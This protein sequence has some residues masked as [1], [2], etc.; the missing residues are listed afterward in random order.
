M[1]RVSVIVPNYN[2]SDTVEQMLLALAEQTEPPETFEVILVDDGST[3]GSASIIKNVSVPYTLRLSRQQNRGAAAAR[4]HGAKLARADLLVFLDS[5]M[6]ATPGLLAQYLAASA[7]HRQA[8]I[9]GRQHPW[10]EAFRSP[11]DRIT[12]LEKF[13]DLGTKRIDVVFYHVVS[14]NMAIRRQ[15]FESLGGFDKSLGIGV[16][17]AC[18][19]TD[20]GYRATK[21]GLDLVYWPE[22]LAYH[23]HPRTFEQRCTQIRLR[24]MWTARL[25]EKHPEM[26]SM[27][28]VYQNVQPISW[29]QDSLGLI[30]R[31]VTAQFVA[32]GP[33]TRT[34]E[35]L[36]RSAARFVQ[37]PRLLKFLYWR[38]LEACRVTGFRMGLKNQPIDR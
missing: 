25:F 6:I 32:F 30:G 31:K 9:I 27:I 26:R 5:D 7:S 35:I 10:R 37:N 20:L 33:V 22:A 15:H 12:R 21:E 2:R 28:P 34:L 14:S 36:L 3:D 16:Q 11:F 24:A 8:V 23:N 4:N 29:R 19:D 1:P 13:R 17:P 38:L 18:E